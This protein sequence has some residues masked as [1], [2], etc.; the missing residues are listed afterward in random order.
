MSLKICKRDVFGNVI[1]KDGK[2]REKSQKAKRDDIEEKERQRWNHRA[3]IFTEPL[4][5]YPDQTI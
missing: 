2:I 4:G 1:N 3:S 5:D